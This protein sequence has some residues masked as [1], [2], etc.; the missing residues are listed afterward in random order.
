MSDK[1]YKTTYWSVIL[2]GMLLVA[3]LPLV[4]YAQEYYSRQPY[5]SESRRMAGMQTYVMDEVLRD[6]TPKFVVNSLFYDAT[7]YDD[8]V[9]LIKT[10]ATVLVHIGLPNP[11]NTLNRVFRISTMGASTAV[12]SNSTAV[13]T[14]TEMFTMAVSSTYSVASNKTATVYSTGTNWVARVH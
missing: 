8:G 7:N 5:P 10:N 13:G 11:T 3:I 14:F 12:L 9:I 6:N 4:I 2:S 1:N